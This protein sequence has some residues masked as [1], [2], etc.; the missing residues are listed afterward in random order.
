MRM[1]M[2]RIPCKDLKESENY[3]THIL[4]FNKLFGSIEEGFVGYRLD[5]IDIMIELQE[6][7]EFECGNFLGF[8]LEVDI[9]VSFIMSP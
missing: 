7:G 8:S 4:G 9:W 1:N 5:N 6:P 3:Y 2:M